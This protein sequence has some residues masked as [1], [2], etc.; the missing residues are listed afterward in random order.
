MLI[1]WK[2]L[3]TFTAG[4]ILVFRVYTFVSLQMHILKQILII[5][6]DFV[7]GICHYE[8]IIYTKITVSE[9]LGFFFNA[10]LNLCS[11]CQAFSQ[12]MMKTLTSAMA[13]PP[14][15]GIAM[16]LVTSGRLL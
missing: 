7:N 6:Y 3:E 10:F 1:S 8:S 15:E 4:G 16:G 11:L 14:I 12:G 13:I 9:V 5:S 2:S